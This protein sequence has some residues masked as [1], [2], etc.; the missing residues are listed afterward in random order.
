MAGVGAIWLWD[1]SVRW[2]KEVGD[3]I[4]EADFRTVWGQCRGYEVLHPG[5]DGGCG[6]GPDDTPISV[7]KAAQR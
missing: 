2:V 1:L 6:P 7:P 3:E 5:F 4:T